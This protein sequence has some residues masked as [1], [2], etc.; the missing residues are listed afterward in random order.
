MCGVDEKNYLYSLVSFV[1]LYITPR[2]KLVKK[3]ELFLTLQKRSSHRHVSQKSIFIPKKKTMFLSRTRKKKSI[4]PSRKGM[5][6]PRTSKQKTIFPSTKKKKK[7]A[8][9]SHVQVSRK[10]KNSI[11]TPTK[12]LPSMASQQKKY[13]CSHVC[14]TTKHISPNDKSAEYVCVPSRLLDEKK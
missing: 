2:G 6:L 9:H 1:A 13:R 11:L 12:Q 5:L 7:K 14:Q 4:F 10:K 3:K 8:F